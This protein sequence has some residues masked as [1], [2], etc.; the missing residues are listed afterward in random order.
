M[1]DFNL[2]GFA[3]L[4]IMSDTEMLVA[5]AANVNDNNAGMV[6]GPALTFPAS[7]FATNF[8]PTS[9]DFNG[10][11]LK[12][13]AWISSDYTVHFATVCPGPV[14]DTICA[15][16]ES[17]D[18]LLD[19][20]QSRAVPIRVTPELPGA[21]GCARN[22]F[23]VVAGNFSSN[24]ADDLLVLD[25]AS[26]VGTLNN[27]Y[28]AYWYQ[29]DGDWKIVGGAPIDQ[30]TLRQVDYAYNILAQAGRLDWSGIYDQVVFVIG[31][32]EFSCTFEQITREFVGVITFNDSKMALAGTVGKDGECQ[33]TN[34]QWPWVNGLAL[35]HFA[36]IA[37][38]TTSDSAFD[39]QIGTL[40]NDGSVR[41]YE[42]S[43][44]ASWTPS[45]VS[46]TTTDSSLAI[47][48][49]PNLPPGPHLPNWLVSGD[50]QGRSARWSA[51]GGTRRQPLAAFGHPGCAAHA[52]G[53][54]PARPEHGHRLGG[55]QLL[56][57]ARHLQQQLHHEPDEQQPV[58]RHQ[59]DELYL[60]NLR[61]G[62]S[63]F[64][65]KL[66][67]LPS[68]SGSIK[69]TTENKN[70]AVSEIYQFT[71]NE[72]TYDASTTT[73]L[74]ERSG[75]ALAR[76]T[77]TTILSWAKPSAPLTTADATQRRATALCDLLGTEQYGDGA[78]TG[79]QH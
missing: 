54:H 23:A 45:L 15:G 42:V 39:Q 38:D 53:L 62:R 59:S 26:P 27:F 44:P 13:I 55:R 31:S 47:N 4:F 71:Q 75:M 22:A 63:L 67:Y 6:F 78:R 30:I 14:A 66:P 1:D 73:G 28:T 11:G 69:T 51:V 2:D 64:S 19:P 77:S 56:D 24:P 35:G 60:C 17:L 74:G 9:G 20:L 61:T 8:D 49:L 32:N 3:D 68:V 76:S 48:F 33:G 34:Q 16:K 10:D 50:L 58:V 79:R 36:S 52:R 21:G 46:Q 18:L 29:F 70:E 65:F 40:L 41:I 43:P 7:S 12:D 25:C 72:F 37:D 57:R 5:T